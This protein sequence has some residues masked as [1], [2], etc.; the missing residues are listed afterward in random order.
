MNKRSSY[1]VNLVIGLVFVAVLIAIA[2]PVLSFTQGKTIQILVGYSPGGG[3]DIEAR[4]IAR[5]IGKYLPGKPKTIIVRNMPGAGGLIEVAHFYNRAKR[6]GL[7]WAII[8]TTQTSSQVLAS[9][10]PNYD[11]HKVPQIFST[12]GS[13]AAIVR[14]FLEVRKGKDIMKV[15]PS[16]IVVSGR[17]L[18]GASFLTD[19]LGLE[20]LGI[21]GYK[22]VV[23]YP[24]TAQMAR[25]FFSGEISYVGGTGLHHVVGKAGRYY[26][27]VQEGSAVPLWQ[28][29]VI[30]PEGKTVRSPGTDVPTLAEIYQEVHG[31]SPSGQVWEAYKLTGPT[32]RTLNRSLSL[33]PGVP[34]DRQATLRQA[35][36]KL[37]ADPAYIKQWEKI[38]GLRLDF[39]PGIDADKIMRSLLQPSPGWN[40]IKNEF[41]PKL[42]AKK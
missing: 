33:P 15:D 16:K 1:L 37:Y 3:H 20:L 30:T 17:T 36:K 14:D 13:G 19:V 10:R 21:K 41:I 9:P 5:W 28:T 34:A 18:V 23:G 42:K 32:V 8:G 12:S 4:L 25:A 2:K 27:A 6:D 22:Y 39:I 7:T 38:F 29:G 26:A 40:F 31:K 35:F 24:G 11:L